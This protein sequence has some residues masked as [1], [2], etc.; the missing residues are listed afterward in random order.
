MSNTIRISKKI[1]KKYKSPIDNLY[2]HRFYQDLF[3]G[4]AYSL[5]EK[6]L[7]RRDFFRVTSSDKEIE[8]LFRNAAHY[9]FS[10]DLEQTIDSALY[11]MAVY[12]KAYLYVKPEYKDIEDESERKNKKLFFLQISEVKGIQEKNIFYYRTFSKEVSKFDIS[13]GTLITLDLKNLGYRRNYFVKLV[14]KLGKYD[15]TS[16][17]LELINEEPTYD[18]SVHVNKNQKRILKKVSDI[19][20]RFGMDGISD[21]YILYKEIKMKL[22]KMRFLHY[23]LEKINEVLVDNYIQDRTFKIEALTK[24][25]N[26]EEIWKKYQCGELT[27]SDLNKIV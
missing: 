14:K 4:Y 13:E 27:V 6:E 17:S 12:G 19:G 10:Y 2:S 1:E 20:W 15:T 24:N 21:S 5:S 11:C 16:S 8:K 25:V 7:D 18:F 3:S 22:F 23:V 9:N 26:Y